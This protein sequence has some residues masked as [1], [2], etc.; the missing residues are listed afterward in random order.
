MNR[1]DVNES[2]ET[3]RSTRTPHPSRVRWAAIGAACAVA[4]GGGGFGVVR[5]VVDEGV[6]SAYV[7]IEP[8][9]VLDTRSGNPVS[10]SSLALVVEGQITVVGAASRTVVPED[11]TAVAINVTVTGGQKR[12][13]YGYVTTYP[14]TSASDAPPN[15]SSLNFENGVDIANALNV[16]TSE[17]GSICLYVWG[18][19]DLIVDVVG[20]YA[21]HNHDDLYPRW[22][23]LYSTIQEVEQTMQT[24]PAPHSYL[25]GEENF[26]SGYD[27]DADV[28]FYGRAILVQRSEPLAGG[29]SVLDLVRCEDFGCSGYNELELTNLGGDP[30]EPSIELDSSGLPIIAYYESAA[31]YGLRLVRCDD[32]YCSATSQ[33]TVLTTGVDNGRE[34]TIATLIDGGV[35]IAYRV[36][37]GTSATLAAKRAMC[38]VPQGACDTIQTALTTADGGYDPSIVIS[39]T[40]IPFIVHFRSD[41]ANSRAF[42]TRCSNTWCATADLTS[43]FMGPSG[44]DAT[45]TADGGL[46]VVGHHGSNVYFIRCLRQDCTPGP[47]NYARYTKAIGSPVSNVSIAIGER[48]LPVGVY[49]DNPGTG[50]RLVSFSCYSS[51]C[52]YYD[53]FSPTSYNSIWTT[54][55]QY[56]YFEPRGQSTDVVVTSNG[57]ALLFDQATDPNSLRTTLGITACANPYC[58]PYLR[59][60]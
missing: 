47:S 45:L 53:S 46:L 7:A 28:D 5:A 54:R 59:T 15:A 18:T 19:A 44:G 26:G 43:E 52:L 6:R 9:R 4:I 20:Y 12:D 13:G 1:H 56:E 38:N 17:S 32:R 16:T 25:R 37:S 48:G 60:P 30:I 57:R 42:V 51:D 36:G 35:L 39:P 55:V 11:A 3:S 27:I 21:D 58:L 10:N 22:G 33:P 40:G 31:P 50:T 41:G 24:R 14:C 8:T 29:N 34:P 2:A 49:S 23:D